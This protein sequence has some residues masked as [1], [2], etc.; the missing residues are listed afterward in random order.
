M[1][2]TKNHPITKTLKKVIDY[3]MGDKVE[4]ALKDDIKD[5]VAY[6]IDDKTGKVIYSTIHSTLNCDRRHPYEMFSDI[7]HTYGAGELWHGNPQTTDGAPIL[8]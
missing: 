7:I 1:A 4:E 3:A 8:A 6:V 5:S 2:T